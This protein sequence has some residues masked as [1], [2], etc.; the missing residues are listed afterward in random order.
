MVSSASPSPLPG[1]GT[2]RTRTRSSAPARRADPLLLM[3]VF[4]RLF[5]H[6]WI[7]E[8]RV[9]TVRWNTTKE[10]HTLAP[11][12]GEEQVRHLEVCRRCGAERESGPRRHDADRPAVAVPVNGSEAEEEE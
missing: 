8:T 3:S 12:V 5:G 4:C 9:P 11:T 1:P 10:G 6:T 7:P 2:L